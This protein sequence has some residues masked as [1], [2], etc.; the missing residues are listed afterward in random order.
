MSA[1]RHRAAASLNQ[2][3]I[4]PND[5]PAT[6]TAPRAGAPR[7]Q[8]RKPATHR[9]RRRPPPASRC[10][11]S[12]A[13]GTR[14]P[15]EAPSRARR[16]GPSRQTKRPRRAGRSGVEERQKN[17]GP[18]AIVSPRA[19]GRQ[20]LDWTRVHCTCAALLPGD[21]STRQQNFVVFVNKTS[22]CCG[23]R[24]EGRRAPRRLQRAHGQA[25]GVAPVDKC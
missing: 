9:I 2:R 18:G 12:A 10:G 16:V 11:R 3:P 13:A 5:S 22:T 15:P 24:A 25:A 8:A 7:I 14:G 6:R 21:D 20:E 23:M 4:D 19:R 1:P 17:R